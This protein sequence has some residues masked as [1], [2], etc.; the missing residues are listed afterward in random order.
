M[1]PFLSFTMEITMKVLD[2]FFPLALSASGAFPH[3]P[4]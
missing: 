2:H 1:L 3:G 4:A